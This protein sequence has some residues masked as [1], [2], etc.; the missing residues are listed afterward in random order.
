MLCTS[1][2]TKTINPIHKSTLSCIFFITF[3]YI[4]CH[5]LL[6]L[7]PLIYNLSC[8]VFLY[9][10]ILY[11]YLSLKILYSPFLF[12]SP[13]PNVFRSSLETI[14]KEHILFLGINW[15]III[16]DHVEVRL[17]KTY[18]RLTLNFTWQHILSKKV[19][20]ILAIDLANTMELWFVNVQLDFNLLCKFW[21]GEVE[22][23]PSSEAGMD[24]P[25]FLSQPKL[26]KR[27]QR[28]RQKQPL[29]ATLFGI[30]PRFSVE[31]VCWS[32]DGLICPHHLFL[33]CCY[34][35]LLLSTRKLVIFLSLLEALVLDGSGSS[36]LFL[37]SH[38]FDFG[39]PCFICFM[40]LSILIY[41][42]LC[43]FG[44]IT[45]AKK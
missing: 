2:F 32:L 36:C 14:A 6:P 21:A 26:R 24:P 12:R 22:E 40:I 1:N 16:W 20:K 8:I 19:S 27:K 28:K 18:Y 11:H 31:V 4:F 35:K 38:G 10:C 9:S 23:E 34:L 30:V 42:G 33:K 41:F 29:K 3:L 37:F 44:R 15:L 7:K 13:T 43:S 25:S 17:A 5:L 45:F 39:L